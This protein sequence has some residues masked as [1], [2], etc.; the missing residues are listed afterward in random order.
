MV[1]EDYQAG[2]TPP[3]GDYK[4]TAISGGYV[5]RYMHYHREAS[6]NGVVFAGVGQKHSWRLKEYG[7]ERSSV[8]TVV[9]KALV[10]TRCPAFHLL[11]DDNCS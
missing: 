9:V 5:N 2:N 8:R 3:S 10:S 6:H 11:T 7:A 1:S 4:T